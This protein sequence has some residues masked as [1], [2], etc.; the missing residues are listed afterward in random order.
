MGFWN[1]LGKI[2]LVAAPYVAAPFTGGASLAF[3]GAANQA[4]KKWSEHDANNAAKKGLAPSSFDKYLGMAG[5]VAGMAGGMG[6]F[7]GKSGTFGS[8]SFNAKGMSGWQNTLGK[9]GSASSNVL[10]QGQGQGYGINS[11][12]PN[13]GG[14][15]ER[16]SI[17]PSQAPGMNRF[18]RQAQRQLGPV[19]G[20]MN[21]SNPNLAESIASGRMDAMRNQPWRGGYDVQTQGDDDQIIT[22]RMPQISPFQRRQQQFSYTPPGTN[23]SPTQDYGEAPEDDMGIEERRKRGVA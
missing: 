19:M 3:T 6:A 11:G 20:N 23:V 2:A 21:Q 10:N 18:N 9:I 4:V 8:N 1:K 14:G 22:S 7:G 17:G 12:S 13:A 5:D 15:Y 16:G